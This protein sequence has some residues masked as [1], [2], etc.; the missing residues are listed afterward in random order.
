MNLKGKVKGKSYEE[1]I[2]RLQEIDNFLDRVKEKAQQG[3]EMS[4]EVLERAVMLKKEREQCERIT[5]CWGSTLEYMYEYFSHDKNPENENNLIPEGIG[6]EDAPAFHRE[7][8]DYLDSYHS[9]PTQRIAWSVPRSHA[10]STYLSNMYPL[11]NIVYNLRSFIVIVSETQDGAK[12]FADYVN[13]QL[14]HN[15]KLREDFG[16]L[17]DETGRGNIKDNAEKF[18]TKNNIMVAIGSTQKQ[19]RGMK[20]LNARPDLIW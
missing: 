14:K 1:W 10:K 9:D 18:V 3:K 16:E 17:M 20:F 8:T 2:N 7:L 13:N 19:L 5:R 4:R 12:L 6:I 15:A 11:Y